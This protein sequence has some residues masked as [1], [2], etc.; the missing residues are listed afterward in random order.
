[1]HTG[2]GYDDRGFLN[3]ETISH[4]GQT[5]SQRTLY[6]D[7]RDRI[8]AF[9]KG[10][11]ASV[12]PMENGH[13]DRF[14]YD[15]EGQLVEAWY[16]A[17]DPANSGAGNWRY[18]GFN[19]DA[20]GNRAGNNFLAN[21]GPMT[22]TRKDNGLN[23]YRAWM[24]FSITNYD[25]DIGLPWGAP[26][27]ANG[28]LMQD[29]NITAGYNALNQPMMLAS[30]ALAPNWMF[31]GYDPL[32]RCVKRWVGPLTATGGVPG[33]DSNPAT[34]LYYDGW[35]L[36][37]EG[38]NASTISQVYMLG[39]QVDDIVADFSVA[40]NQW[41]YHHADARGHCV[42]LTDRDGVLAEQYEYDA[43]GQPYFF[44]ASGGQ[45]ATGHSAFGNRFLFTGREYLSDLKLYDYRARMYQ[46]ELGRF[47]QPD[48]KEFG[49][50]DYNLYRYCHNDPVNRSDPSG[51]ETL[52]RPEIDEQVGNRVAEVP[53]VLSQMLSNLAE[54]YEQYV[55][56]P[57][58]H[59]FGFPLEQAA[60]QLAE[61]SALRS[62]SAARG[63]TNSSVNVAAHGM[64]HLPEGMRETVSKAIQ[65]DLARRGAPEVGKSVQ[66]TIKVGGQ[67]VSYRART[68]EGG[69]TNVGTA[70]PGKF[71]RDI[72]KGE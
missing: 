27:A 34:Y 57:F 10:S 4:G 50:G 54:T 19:Y 63:T 9:Q 71:K 29:G 51:L 20:L 30:N 37:Q 23:Q 35:S 21:H 56:Q 28:V 7:D 24:P 45:T 69:K 14:R 13:G 31:F 26:A 15:D 52:T 58:F 49:A 6:R 42:L 1:M 39:N 43:F 48:P 59:T 22:F 68:L 65:R 72:T 17:S 44:D 16:G 32:G 8:T 12:N 67:E 25:D 36:I 61:M 47:M 5:Y 53:R 64:R 11:D 3:Q 55:A 18:D 33:P 62:L 41:M 40:N 60:P 2:F 66:R 70:I 38:P 46:P